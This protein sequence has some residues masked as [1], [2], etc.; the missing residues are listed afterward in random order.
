MAVLN[1][2]CGPAI[3]DSPIHRARHSRPDLLSFTLLDFSEPTIDY[4]RDPHR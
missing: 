2:G 3:E 4:T 1:V